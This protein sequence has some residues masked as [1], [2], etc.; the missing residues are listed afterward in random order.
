M[1]CLLD[2]HKKYT[3][4]VRKAFENDATFV[5]AMDRACKKFVNKNAVT[6]AAKSSTKSPEL[7]AKYCH[8]L[9]KKGSKI[10]EGQD[11]ELL[12]EGV[13]LV[14]QY[15]EDNDVFQVRLLCPCKIQFQT[16]CPCVSR[17]TTRRCLHNVSLTRRQNL[18][19]MSPA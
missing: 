3:E 16:N 6:V 5:A 10:A 11:V 7:L 9:L 17:N 15:L 4:M 8:G 12:L 1:D 2:V 19:I 13:M 18:T 14:F